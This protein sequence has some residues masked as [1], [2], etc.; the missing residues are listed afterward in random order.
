MKN[1]ILITLILVCVCGCDS[2]CDKSEAGAF[3][4]LLQNSVVNY[5]DADLVQ[6]AAD[7]WKIGIVVKRGEDCA[8][9]IHVTDQLCS[10]VFS[11]TDRINNVCPVS[12]GNGIFLPDSI[13]SIRAGMSGDILVVNSHNDVALRLNLAHEIGHALGFVHSDSERDLMYPIGLKTN[14]ASEQELNIL[15]SVYT[16][17][18]GTA[19]A[20]ASGRMA[21]ALEKIDFCYAGSA[22]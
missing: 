14:R 11:V 22:F 15:E 16:N 21:W 2:A 1:L 13:E 7:M 8:I 4:W 10:T 19:G 12:A 5:D 17:G 18:S 20:L 9:R 3:S 6:S